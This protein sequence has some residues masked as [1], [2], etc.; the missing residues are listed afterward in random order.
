MGGDWPGKI[1]RATCY[2]ARAT[3]LRRPSVVAARVVSGLRVCRQQSH[4]SA[5]AAAWVECNGSLRAVWVAALCMRSHSATKS[6]GGCC[7]QLQLSSV[8]T[9]SSRAKWGTRHAG[10][11]C[12]TCTSLAHLLRHPFFD[13]SLTQCV[14]L[15]CSPHRW[16][17]HLAPQ[18]ADF[19][20]LH[21]SLDRKHRQERALL[22]SASR[23][24]FH[25]KPCITTPSRTC[26]ITKVSW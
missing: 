16:R 26:A 5:H 12:T 9:S 10:T 4:L 2:S 14:N 17:C 15:L 20:S 23:R 3:A 22:Q 7:R 13:S 21:V 11:T 18:E 19:R 1:G 24:T 8:K 6:S 25:I